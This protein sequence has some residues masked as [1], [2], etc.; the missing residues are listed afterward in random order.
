MFWVVHV[1]NGIYVKPSLL[2]LIKGF[3]TYGVTHDKLG[4]AAERHTRA[5]G[6][7]A[8]A[9]G[10]REGHVLVCR[11]RSGTW[12]TCKD[13]TDLIRLACA[14]VCSKEHWRIPVHTVSDFIVVVY[15]QHIYAHITLYA[16]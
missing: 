13:V 11:G 2:S 14:G 15:V 10:R 8:E 1:C 9:W 5:P 7:V 6:E 4:G 12:G 16:D 3:I